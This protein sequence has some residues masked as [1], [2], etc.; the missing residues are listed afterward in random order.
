M[1][2]KATPPKPQPAGWGDEGKSQPSAPSTEERLAK[3]ESEHA[4]LLIV[5]DRHGINLPS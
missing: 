1:A 3:L 2:G 5:L 4:Q